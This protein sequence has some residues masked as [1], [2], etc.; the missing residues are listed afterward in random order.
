[1]FNLLSIKVNRHLTFQKSFHS[2]KRKCY[3]IECFIQ[4]YF[5][6]L[7][8]ILRDSFNAFFRTLI[9]SNYFTVTIIFTGVAAAAG[10]REFPDMLIEPGL[11]PKYAFLVFGVELADQLST[12]FLQI[13]CVRWIIL[14][15][16]KWQSAKTNTLKNNTHFRRW[17]MSYGALKLFWIELSQIKNI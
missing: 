11:A 2:N 14:F 8:N 4:N 15:H 9:H 6:N 17:S 10:L 13:F 5:W 12:G 16:P 7:K 1:M 3:L